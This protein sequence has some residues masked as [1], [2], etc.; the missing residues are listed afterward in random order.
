MLGKYA[1]RIQEIDRAS[2]K[3]LREKFKL[4]RRRPLVEELEGSGLCSADVVL[5]LVHADHRDAAEHVM[6]HTIT[7]YVP[8]V[9]RWPPT[10]PKVRINEDQKKVV[11]VKPTNPKMP[12]TRAHTAFSL[13]KV[14]MT[15]VQLLSR[16][17]TRRDI[18]SWTRAGYVEFET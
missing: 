11:F 10:K 8:Y 3:V 18:R 14:G 12:G 16:G 5:E 2:Q 4:H 13:V 6:G 1:K 17:V 9:P 15:K 7:V